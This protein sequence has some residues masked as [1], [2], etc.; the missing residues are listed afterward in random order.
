MIY[1]AKAIQAK[2]GDYTASGE[3]GKSVSETIS[4]TVANNTVTF[5]KEQLVKSQKYIH[6]R[7]AL[8]ALLDDEKHYTFAQVDK[9]LKDFDE[10]GKK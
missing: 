3:L 1:L 10:G 6:R 5:S 9:V 7:D 8:N 2:V 4:K